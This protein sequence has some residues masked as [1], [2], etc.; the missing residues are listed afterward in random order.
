MGFLN[1]IIIYGLTLILA[2]N[3]LLVAPKTIAQ[4][5]DSSQYN[6][7]IDAQTSVSCVSGENYYPRLSVYWNLSGS[8]PQNT[9]NLQWVLNING[10]EGHIVGP[11]TINF[12]ANRANY[13]DYFGRI[14]EGVSSVW[15]GDRIGWNKN[16]KITVDL[17]QNDVP[18]GSSSINAMTGPPQG[19]NGNSDSNYPC[20]PQNLKAFPQLVTTSK[21][22]TF[23]V[24][25]SWDKKSM[26]CN[27]KFELYRPGSDGNALA[28]TKDNLEKFKAYS[29]G[30]SYDFSKM[31]TAPQNGTYTV[32]SID[33]DS[34]PNG[35]ATVL[36]DL[37]AIAS[38]IANSS[39]NNGATQSYVDAGVVSQCDSKCGSLISPN[40]V[41]NA[42]CQSQCAVIGWIG[43][44]LSAVINKVLMPALGICPSGTTSTPQ[45][46]KDNTTTTPPATT[47]PAT[48]PTANPASP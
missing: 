6:P 43:E 39:T 4:T 18:I 17:R 23:N 34:R 46:C 19:I 20:S 44:M 33:P 11:K 35:I 37:S 26:S 3:F 24:I 30:Y 7:V 31:D 10:D 48:T 27:A 47:P 42:L 16:Y 29:L 8:K 38:A 22:A 45:G 25:F 28:I 13:A 2:T 1:K 14:C 40:A 36:V 9:E 15:A 41:K 5:S 12:E 32:V 21:S